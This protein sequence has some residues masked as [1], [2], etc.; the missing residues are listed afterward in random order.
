MAALTPGAAHLTTA[1]SLTCEESRV[2]SLERLV[3][4]C[5]GRQ[6][7]APLSVMDKLKNVYLNRKN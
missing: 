2:K 6:H 7:R 3:R 5:S 4:G 1:C